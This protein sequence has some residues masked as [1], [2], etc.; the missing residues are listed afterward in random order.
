MMHIQSWIRGNV[1]CLLQ[2]SIDVAVAYAKERQAF[3]SPIAKLQS[4]QV[5]SVGDVMAWRVRH[6]TSMPEAVRSS[7][8]QV[9]LHSN[10]LRLGMNPSLLPDCTESGSIG[11]QNVQH[12]K[13]LH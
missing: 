8:T 12:L 4:I 13:I 11:A 10:T 5:R 2:A 3:G 1:D 9:R 7:P 6:W